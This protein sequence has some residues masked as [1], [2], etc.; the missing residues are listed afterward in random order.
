MSIATFLVKNHRGKLV[1]QAQRLFNR[2]IR[3][4]DKGKPCIYCGKPINSGFHGATAGHYLPVSTAESLRFDT[5]N[6]HLAGL[7]CNLHD[8]RSAYRQNLLL[9]IGEERVLALEKRQHE[10]VRMTKSE[11][12]DK[13]ELFKRINT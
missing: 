6:V 12:I 9:R 1:N 8:D 4:R 10:L 5:D 11:I 13:I 2:Y 3:K 7:L